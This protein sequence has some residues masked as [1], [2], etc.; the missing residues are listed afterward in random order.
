M[1]MV[2]S[3]TNTQ[4]THLSQSTNLNKKKGNDSKVLACA[5]LSDYNEVKSVDRYVKKDRNEVSD[6]QIRVLVAEVF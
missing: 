6:R 4:M 2:L 5:L 3:E 1:M